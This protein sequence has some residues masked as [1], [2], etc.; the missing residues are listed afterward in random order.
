MKI[1]RKTKL[2]DFQE[3]FSIYFPHVKMIFYQNAHEKNEFSPYFDQIDPESSIGEI[4]KKFT[5][6]FFHIIPDETVVDFE[7]R[8]QKE[9]GL[10]VQVFRKVDEAWVQT[11]STDD[12]TL[13]KEEENA[14]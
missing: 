7:A 9:F 2:S 10:N 4:N 12:W 6:K 11:T 3:M 13:L 8:L 5:E 14:Y 1:T